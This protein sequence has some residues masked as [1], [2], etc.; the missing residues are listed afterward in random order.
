MDDDVGEIGQVS[1]E[2]V[3]LEFSGVQ[4]GSSV[5]VHSELPDDPLEEAHGEG[6]RVVDTW[7]VEAGGCGGVWQFVVSL[8][9]QRRSEEGLFGVLHFSFHS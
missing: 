8:E 7:G 4:V 1:V 5:L 3:V 2:G 6:V 9:H